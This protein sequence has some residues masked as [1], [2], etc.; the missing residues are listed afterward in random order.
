MIVP[1]DIVIGTIAIGSMS[2]NSSALPRV[3]DPARK[4]ATAE[5]FISEA[6]F[7]QLVVPPSGPSLDLIVPA[8]I[9]IGT[10]PLVSVSGNYSALPPPVA[11]T[12][13]T[14]PSRAWPSGYGGCPPATAHVGYGGGPSAP[15]PAGYSA[16]P[17]APAPAAGQWP[18]GYS[19]GFDLRKYCQLLH[20]FI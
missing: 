6:S 8:D 20:Y 12:D 11:L 16:G 13:L 5:L 2:R 14:Q 19:S 3:A 1:V 7:F 17:P 4:S 10:I 15:V 9:V 18:A